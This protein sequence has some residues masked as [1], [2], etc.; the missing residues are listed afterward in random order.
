[1]ASVRTAEEPALFVRDGENLPDGEWVG[2]RADRAV[3]LSRMERPYRVHAVDQRGDIGLC[4]E[5]D[6]VQA[7]P[8]APAS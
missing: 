1:M 8:L 7:L 3:R 6:F 5:T 2:V 4:S